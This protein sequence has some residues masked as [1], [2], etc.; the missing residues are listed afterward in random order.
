MIREEEKF[1]S[2]DDRRRLSSPLTFPMKFIF[3]PLI[4]LFSG[5][6]SIVS[7]FSI[8]ENWG[9]IILGLILSV[10]TY[11]LFAQVK[12]VEVD[13]N[14]IYISNYLKMVRVP[15]HA[16]E[17]ISED[18]Y[19]TIRPVYVRFAYKTEFGRTVSFLPKFHMWFLD[20]H[21]VVDE[22]RRLSRGKKL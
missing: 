17:D 5:L 16:I 19:L 6:L 22:L 13:D 2:H 11:L 12:S 14:F 10:I 7:L 18:R 1:K 15:L 4:I 9:F 20:P 3:T 21:P 8:K